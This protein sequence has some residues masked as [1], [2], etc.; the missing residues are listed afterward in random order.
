V[1]VGVDL[2]YVD[3]HSHSNGSVFKHFQ[4]KK[5]LVAMK[6]V[7]GNT[8][9]AP[10]QLVTD[11]LILE[12]NI[13][14]NSART[15]ST[16]LNGAFIHGAELKPLQEVMDTEL[17]RRNDVA[18]MI[19]S[20]PWKP[21]ASERVVISELK[22]V[23]QQLIEFKN[24][25]VEQHTLIQKAIKTFENKE[26]SDAFGAEY[27]I[28]KN[29]SARFG[30]KNSQIIQLIEESFLNEI[31]IV[32]Q[33]AEVAAAKPDCSKTEKMAHELADFILKYQ[34]Y[35][36]ST[37]K[38]LKQ[39][40]NMEDHTCRSRD[41]TDALDKKGNSGDNRLELARNFRS[42]GEI[43]QAVREYTRCI[44]TNQEEPS[45]YQE[46]V[47]IFIE[48]EL[49]G[50]AQELLNRAR[51]IFVDSSVFSRQ[52]NDVQA[53]ID[54]ILEDIKDA[55][56]L[57]NHNETQKLLNRY[58]MLRPQDAQAIEIESAMQI[59][60]DESN[61]DWDDEV[62]QNTNMQTRFQQAVQYIKKRQFELGIGILEG[63]YDDFYEARA[64]LREQI[65][66][67]RVM[68]KDYQSA[69]W[70]FCQALNL[71]PDKIEINHKIS[72]LNSIRA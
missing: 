39:L 54:G 27:G 26:N 6:G 5:D 25:C 69:K 50:A 67:I 12:Q 21:A 3:G 35:I 34:V 2:A 72:K 63:L 32:I 52:Q 13:S 22:K 20:I 71:G 53:G 68:Q 33:S 7:R 29:E 57:G 44:K 41:L 55:W 1:L 70:H 24:S 59:S 9:Y 62:N 16:S 47:Q 28:I 38:L 48:A 58:L 10:P 49:W 60:E 15:I 4:Q 37:E 14:Q 51:S 64:M 30:I 40:K 66:D 11:R 19:D 17:L 61:A 36:D 42:C 56:A 45:A 43:W 8:V 18:G 23:I 65:G 31:Q 46:L